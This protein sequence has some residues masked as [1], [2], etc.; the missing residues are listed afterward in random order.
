MGA[1]F[2]L[3]TMAL[4]V[5]YLYKFCLDLMK[6]NQ[7]GGLKAS[8]FQY[9]WNDAQ[10]AYQS[11]LVGRFEPRGNNKS[12]INTG[13][14][15]NATILQKLT[16][17]TKPYSLSVSGVNGQATK[18]TDFIFELGLMVGTEDVFK[19][20]KDQKSPVLKSVI[21]PPST[22]DGAYYATEYE[23]YYQFFPTAAYTASLDYICAVT[24]VVWGFT[25]DGDGRQVYDAGTSV[26]PLWDN[27]SCRDITKRMFVNLGVSFKDNDFAQFGQKVQMTGE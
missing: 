14:I 13:L 19:I 26:Q 21:D 23:D 17:F 9:E 6:K 7:A 4:S 24:A 10:S 27:N 22:A 18:P 15:Q 12:G 16:P 11:D 1:F 25:F 3:Y 8:A 5:D 20:T 2:Q